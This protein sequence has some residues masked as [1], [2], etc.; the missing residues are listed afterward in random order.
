MARG[1]RTW[2]TVGAVWRCLAGG[3]WAWEGAG[4][5][6]YVW[7]SN[8]FGQ[9]GSLT[10]RELA[11]QEVPMGCEVVAVAACWYQTFMVGA[12]GALWSCGRNACSLF[13]GGTSASRLTPTKV[14]TGVLTAA[15]GKVCSLAVADPTAM[16]GP[17]LAA[18]E[19]DYGASRTGSRQTVLVHYEASAGGYPLRLD[20]VH[21][22]RGRITAG[23]SLAVAASLIPL[24]AKGAVA[25]EDGALALTLAAKGVGSLL[26]SGLPARADLCLALGLDHATRTLTGPATLRLDAG[27]DSGRLTAPCALALPWPMDGSFA[28]RFDL[29]SAE[30]KVTGTAELHLANGTAY[31]LLVKRGRVKGTAV[32]LALVGDP[33]DPAARGLAIVA[34]ITPLED[35]TARI[36]ALSARALGQGLEW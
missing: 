10:G 7:G 3:L 11:L 36:E 25:G 31:A 1:F 15:A 32:T 27:A 2:V 24:A 14:M 13:G 6:L 22:G 20:V 28:L 12:D 34:T 18:L 16:V 30:R 8:D 19:L 26:W 29:V 5:S 9:L 33:A 17:A 4:G 23:G 35:G 21:D